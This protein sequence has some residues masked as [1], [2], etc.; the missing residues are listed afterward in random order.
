MGPEVVLLL[1]LLL[2]AL[3]R[4]SSRPPQ[5]PETFV[6]QVGRPDV[7]YDRGQ[8]GGCA[9]L[10]GALVMLVLLVVVVLGQA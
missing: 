7:E 8:A 1:L 6:W 2:L 5:A 3:L 9:P 4:P 10:L